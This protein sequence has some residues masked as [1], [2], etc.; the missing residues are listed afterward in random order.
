MNNAQFTF[1]RYIESDADLVYEEYAKYSCSNIQPYFS[2]PGV[3]QEKIKFLDEFQKFSQNHYRPPIIANAD[4]RPCGI[5]EIRYHRANYYNEL[6]L[7]LWSDKHLTRA[8]LKEVIDQSLGKNIP[9][10]YVLV[11]VPGYAP[12]LKQAAEDLG[13][14]LVGKIPNYL[15]HDDELHHKYFF[16]TSFEQWHSLND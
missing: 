15:R 8:V 12:E 1:R 16:I 9:N 2:G 11:E 13:L 7:Y 10:Q 6:S 4:N 14:D 3:I 5:Y